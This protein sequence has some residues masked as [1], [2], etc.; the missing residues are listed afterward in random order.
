MFSILIWTTCEGLL[1]SIQECTSAVRRTKPI[2]HHKVTCQSYMIFMHHIC[3]YKVENIP[4][5]NYGQTCTTNRHPDRHFWQVRI[6]Q[7][8]PHN[9]SF[10]LSLPKSN[11]S[12]SVC[13]PN[14]LSYWQDRINLTPFNWSSC[15]LKLL[16]LILS[17]F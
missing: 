3:F 11:L 13:M 6:K 5:T 12:V 14:N 9:F 15:V 2:S 8:W 7:E 16:T 4:V 10:M 1:L 17:A